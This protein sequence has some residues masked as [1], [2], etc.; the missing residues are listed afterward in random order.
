MPEKPFDLTITEAAAGIAGGKLTPLQL[1]ESCLERI[2][3]VDGEIKAWV[4]LDREGALDQ[5]RLLDRELSDGKSR[6]PLHGIPVG[7]KDIFYV[8]GLRNEAGSR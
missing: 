6:G 1:T 7:I 3:A 5:A 8:A 2:D 4:Q